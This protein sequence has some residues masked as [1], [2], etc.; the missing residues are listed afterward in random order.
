M[1]FVVFHANVIVNNLVEKTTFTGS[2]SFRQRKFNAKG[3]PLVDSAC[4]RYSPIEHLHL[5]FDHEESHTLAFHMPVKS[6]VKPENL[7]FFL[8]K[9]DADTIV[10][11]L[12]DDT[13]RSM[14]AFYFYMWR[15][16]GMAVFDTI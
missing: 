13:A 2:D 7:I 10:A 1:N 5:A 6:F 14:C 4:N 8:H 9:V 12:K 3:C 16:V 11:K 15:M